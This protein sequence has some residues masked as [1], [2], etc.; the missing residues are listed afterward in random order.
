MKKQSNPELNVTELFA[1]K[2]FAAK[3]GVQWKS[4]L[5]MLWMKGVDVG[6]ELQSV[7]N[8][9]GPSGLQKVDLSDNNSYDVV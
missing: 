8:K 3:A 9:V 2:V 7:R 4:K 5:M 6:P 1:L